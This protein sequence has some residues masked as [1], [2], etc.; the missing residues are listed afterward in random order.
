MLNIEHLEKISLDGIWRFQLL[1]SPTDTSHKKWSKIEVPGLWTMQPHSQIFFDKP[2]YTNVQM[3]FEEQPPNVPENNPTGIYERDFE[4][5]SAWSGKRIVLHLGGYESVALIHINGKEVGLTKD[6]HLA[7][8]FDITPFLE[9]GKNTVRITVVKWSDATFIEDQ[10]HW[11]HGGISRSVKLY[12]TNSVFIDRLYTTAGLEADN[13]TGT[14]KIEAHISSN[15]INDLHGYTLRARIEELPKVSAANLEKTLVTKVA[16]NWTELSEK[17]RHAEIEK[18]KS[19]DGTVSKATDAILAQVRADVPGKI[20]LESRNPKVAPWSAET[21]HL[22][23]LAFELLSPDGTILQIGSQ[24][25]GFRDVRVVGKDLLVNGKAITIYGVNRHDFNRHTGR[26]LTRD[27]MR[28]DLL[29]MK[30]W[31]F[32]AVRTSHYPNDPAFLDLTDELNQVSALIIELPPNMHAPLIHHVHCI[33]KVQ[34][35]VIGARVLV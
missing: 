21:P 34:S 20:L 3:P 30:R 29:E 7:A 32:N 25:I 23:T 2:I 22:Y 14:L 13:S 10:D 9:R 24:K 8:E 4:I 6:S 35:M 15:E 26:V 1:A 17:A 5:P 27:D 28:E 33:M 16:P 12:A 11:W 18:R 19:W 31:N